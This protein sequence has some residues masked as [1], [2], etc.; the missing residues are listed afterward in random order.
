MKLD[1][2]IL[3]IEEK[4]MYELRSLYHKSGYTPFKMSRFEEYDMYVKNKS[5]IADTDIVTFT[6]LTGKL[7]ALKPDVTLS[8]IKNYKPVQGSV[9]KVYYNEN[10]YRSDK[11]T[12]EINEIMQTGIECMGDI[13]MAEECEVI[14]LAVKSLETISENYILDISSAKILNG[15]LDASGADI[16][17]RKNIIKLFA[18]KNTPALISLCEEC[19][20]GGAIADIMVKLCSLSGKATE[21]LG[22]L[23]KLCINRDMTDALNELKVLIADLS[24]CGAADKLNLD[25]SIINDTNYYSGVVFRG[26]VDKL[27]ESVLS[28]GRYDNLIKN[29]G[30]KGSAVGFA[31][32]SDML[33]RLDER[34][35]EYDCDV[36]LTYEEGTSYADINNAAEKFKADGLCVNV[37][38]ADN[39]EIRY[40]KLCNIKKGGEVTNG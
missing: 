5:Y 2:N 11:A 18:A 38:K 17:T 33:E 12:H 7:L 9:S 20:I 35:K 30:K 31:V 24:Q 14:L 36:L 22:E 25:F 10:V 19:G 16:D 21:K 28:G 34:V 37:Q 40:K 39:G 29:M 26:Y 6:D 13:G 32:Y 27:P 15:L 3:K 4:I 8:I 23:E 1:E